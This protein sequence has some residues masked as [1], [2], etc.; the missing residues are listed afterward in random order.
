MLDNPDTK[1]EDKDS[2]K[3]ITDPTYSL[4]YAA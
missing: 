2:S 3:Q 1:T 4:T